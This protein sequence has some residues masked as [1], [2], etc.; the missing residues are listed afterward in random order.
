MQ[1][2]RVELDL[3]MASPST[4]FDVPMAGMSNEA[5]STDKR[6]YSLSYSC[7]EPKGSSNQASRE[8]VREIS[9]LIWLRCGKKAVPPTL[10]R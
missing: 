4:V 10:C 5:A 1:I 7:K 9:M 3:S 8:A 2:G 6:I